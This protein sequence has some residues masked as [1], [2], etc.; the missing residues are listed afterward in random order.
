MIVYLY[1][2]YNAFMLYLYLITKI[3]II[4]MLIHTLLVLTNR[5]NILPTFIQCIEI[6]L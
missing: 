2:K 5:I 4:K 1:Y 6:I 3:I